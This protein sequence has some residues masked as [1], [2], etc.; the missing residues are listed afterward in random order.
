MLA[1]HH[2]LFQF[3][4]VISQQSMNLVV[5]FV[6]D[7]VNLWTKVLP[8]NR[9]ILIEQGLNLIMVL[10]KQRPHLLLL[11]RSQLQ[12]LRKARKFL[13][14]RLRCMNMLKLLACGGLLSF[15][16]SHAKTSRSEHEHNPICKRV[17]S[18][19]HGPGHPCESSAQSMPRD[20][21]E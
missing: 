18:I 14:N 8:R 16:L 17:R 6:A 21:S 13:V 9:R 10:L 11:F 5:R 19:S 3:F 4:L 12:I 20:R 15:S 7:R 1:L 2:R